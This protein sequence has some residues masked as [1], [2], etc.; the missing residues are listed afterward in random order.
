MKNDEEIL[1]L[2]GSFAEFSGAGF[3]LKP[4]HSMCSKSLALF[5]F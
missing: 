5:D 3:V 1:E 2:A 4:L